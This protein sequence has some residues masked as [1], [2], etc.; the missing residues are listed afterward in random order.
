MGKFYQP[1]EDELDRLAEINSKATVDH[2]GL[3]KY[4]AIRRKIQE[5]NKLNQY[6]DKFLARW[7][8]YTPKGKLLKK[9]H[10][11]GRTNTR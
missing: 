2:E 8:D 3:A 1:T 9:A 4:K 5:A 10:I 11:S 6:K 7:Y